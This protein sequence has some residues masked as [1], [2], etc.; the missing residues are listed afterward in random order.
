[1]P[2]A[3]LPVALVAGPMVPFSSPTA[4][5]VAP[6]VVRVAAG[7]VPV[8]PLAVPVV[9][10]PAPV[11]AGPALVPP[12]VVPARALRAGRPCFRVAGGIRR[13]GPPGAGGRREADALVPPRL[14]AGPAPAGS[15]R[16]GRLVARRAGVRRP[17]RVGERRRRR[18]LQ[19]RAADRDRLLAGRAPLDGHDHAATGGRGPGGRP[20]VRGRLGGR[21]RG[22][23]A[24]RLPAAPPGRLDLDHARAA[25]VGSRWLQPVRHRAAERLHQQLAGRHHGRQRRGR[26][27]T[28]PE[29]DDQRCV[30]TRRHARRSPAA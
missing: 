11:A 18:F 22:A 7:T 8:G 26:Q 29:G 16:A 1:M 23:A 15:R 6:L 27:G 12:V 21:C 25:Q 20:T 9:P 4:V 10:L 3:A 2:V 17:D 24:G 19:D 28:H 13:P 30:A 5:V 14:V